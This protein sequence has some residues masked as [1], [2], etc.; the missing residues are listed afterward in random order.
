MKFFIRHWT[1]KHLETRNGVILLISITQLLAITLLILRILPLLG[2]PQ[3]FIIGTMAIL[4]TALGVAST[5]IASNFIGGLYILITRPFH[6]G[7]FIRTQR[8]EG[9][10]E[11]IGLNY[12]KIV[13]IDNTKVTI[14]N[15]NLMATSL[16]NFN[17]RLKEIKRKKEM[18][19]DE[20]FLFS[21]HPNPPLKNVVRYR[22]RM[23]LRLDVLNPPIPNNV[24]KERLDK[25]CDE[26][27][28]TFSFKPTYYFGKYD[29]RQEL[30]LIITAL[31]GYTI[32]N[33]WRYFTEAIMKAVFKEL[34]QEE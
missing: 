5:S 24:V 1:G 6:V 27:T 33:T 12:T 17:L 4:A 18:L 3:E 32:F 10:V 31:N 21:S 25:V 28:P 23:E 29:F 9:I 16:L 15:N 8:V 13:R 7:D 20:I 14:P 30:F 19:S 26:F 22:F 2:I 11:E 34:Q